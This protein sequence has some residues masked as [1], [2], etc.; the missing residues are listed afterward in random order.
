M[1]RVSPALCDSTILFLLAAQAAFATFGLPL[2]MLLCSVPLS[3]EY[4]ILVP[5]HCV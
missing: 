5:R 4:A 1:R 3:D 2:D